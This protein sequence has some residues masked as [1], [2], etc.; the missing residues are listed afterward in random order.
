[1]D[2]GFWYQIP[3]HLEGDAEVG[4]IVRI[5]LSGRR[6]RGWVVEVDG[7]REGELKPLV[8]VSGDAPVFDLELLKTLEWA[9]MH[10]VAPLPVLLSKATPPNLPRL[11]E[12]PSALGPGATKGTHPIDDVVASAVGGGRRPNLALVGSWQKLDWLG[13][14]RALIA[15]GR[16]VL[17]IAATAAEV[18]T[19]LAAAEHVVGASLVGVAGEDDAATTAAWVEAQSPGRL[20]VGTPRTAV[21]R[22]PALSL[23]V[24]LEEGRRAMKERHTP[25][26]HVRDVMRRRSLVEG[27]SSVFFGPTPSVEVLAAGSE[28]ARVGNRAWPLVEIVDRSQEPPG[29]GLIT[30][31]VIAA[32]RAVTSRGERCFVFTFRKMVDQCIHEINARMGAP[33]AGPHPHDRSITVG[34]ER[35]LAAIGGL[36]LTV[37][38]NV[39]G[40][41]LTPG[42]RATEEALRLLARLANALAPGP[43]H[44]MMAQV[45]DV[46]LPIVK[47][48]KRGDPIPYLEQVLVERGRAHA[49]PSTEMIAIEIRE[50]VPADAGDALVA[51]PEI[52]VLGPLALDNGLRWLIQGRLDKARAELRD[53]V[54]RWREGGATVR[55]D[56]DPIDI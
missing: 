25:T 15:S 27:F 12:T 31:A 21:W 14:L 43:Q 8:A 10:Y 51:L 56:A 33:K 19:I 46:T 50:S 36:G 40:L 53:L 41:F 32:L 3:E 42:Y 9:A 1:M 11:A 28:V 49:P 34:T 52:E 18:A 24:V 23:V 55:V 37:A 44:R 26:L 35:D 6:V 39:D 45:M 38:A 54:G 2:R 47:T 29:S 20:V 5:P 4:R 30:D 48:L 7:E 13:S 16:T 17:V 22:I